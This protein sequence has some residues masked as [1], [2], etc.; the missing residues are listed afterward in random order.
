MPLYFLLF[1]PRKF[2]KLARPLGEGWARRALDPLQLVCRDLRAAADKFADRFGMTAGDLV[3]TQALRGVALDRNLWRTLIGEIL[4]MTA[5]E[6][7]EIETA[8]QAL[9]CLLAP[10]RYRERVG[11]R[12]CYAPIEQAHFGSRDLVFGHAYYRPEHAGWN[13]VEDVARLAQYFTGIDPS[14]WQVSY[15]AELRDIDPEDR[16]DELDYARQCFGALQGLYR[17]AA[18]CGRIVVCEEI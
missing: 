5:E 11:Q 14:V 6:V 7:P 9:T 2:K 17:G 13:D 10:H 18:D 4:L 12:E 16:A 15:L 8:P 3:I 1:D